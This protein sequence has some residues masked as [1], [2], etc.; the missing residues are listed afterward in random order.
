MNIN[1]PKAKTPHVLVFADTQSWIQ[2]FVANTLRQLHVDFTLIHPGVDLKQNHAQIMRHTH[3]VISWESQFRF[4][5]A[6]I[7][8]LI[9]LTEELNPR[10]QVIILTQAPSQEDV[11]YFGELGVKKVLHIDKD[12]E[13][14]VPQAKK[15]LGFFKPEPTSTLSAW[16]SL[17][18]KIQNLPVDIESRVVRQLLQMVETYSPQDEEESAQ[19]YDAKAV[20]Y[21]AAGEY[22]LAEDFWRRSLQKNAKYHLAHKNYVEFL[23]LRNRYSEAIDHLLNLHQQNS[24]NIARI[25]DIG[26]AHHKLEKIDIAEKY[27]EKALSKDKYHSGAL[28]GLATIKFD[29]GKL[30]E[31]KKL[32]HRS[33]KAYEAAAL[34]NHQGIELV[35][36]DKFEEAL[37]HYS[38]AQYVLPDHE[39]GPLLFYNMGLCYWR[40]NQPAKAREYIKI[41]LIKNPK[42]EKAKALLEAID[43]DMPKRLDRKSA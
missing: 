13:N 6:L 38:R 42:Y 43:A 41:A 2:T 16:Q 26:A 34:L 19:K 1:D 20:L 27:Y 7:Q 12:V 37:K 24:K 22:E 33:A 29:Q 18:R 11:I 28:N 10:E 36:K 39:K 4:G 32:L 40:W 14:L 23:K 31:S 3:F 5:G 9:D 8:S 30:D 15:M 21:S 35:M 25:V 17:L